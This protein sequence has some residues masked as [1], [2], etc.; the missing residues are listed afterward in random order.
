[1][2]VIVVVVVVVFSSAAAN[3]CFAGGH[4]TN[5]MWKVIYS[6]C[7]CIYDKGKKGKNIEFHFNVENLS[8]RD[9]QVLYYFFI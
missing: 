7:W 9:I 3:G 8:E 2:G 5:N 1:M 4:G 6:M